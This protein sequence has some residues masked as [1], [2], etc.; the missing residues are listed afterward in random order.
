[1]TVLLNQAK[2]EAAKD[3]STSSSSTPTVT[4]NVIA[5]HDF[6]VVDL[7]RSSAAKKAKK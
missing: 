4:P 7:S 2:D 6:M 3:H 5:A 1:M